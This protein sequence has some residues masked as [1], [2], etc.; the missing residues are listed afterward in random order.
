MTSDLAAEVTDSL[1]EFAGHCCH[2]PWQGLMCPGETPGPIILRQAPQAPRRPLPVPCAST[3]SDQSALLGDFAFLLWDT[4]FAV[5]DFKRR[6]RFLLPKPHLNSLPRPCPGSGFLLGHKMFS[7]YF[8]CNELY[9]VLNLGYQIARMSL[10]KP[11]RLQV[12]LSG[13]TLGERHTETASHHEGCCLSYSQEAAV[14]IKATVIKKSL[15]KNQTHPLASSKRR[16]QRLYLQSAFQILCK[17]IS[18]AESKPQP[19]RQL[20]E[21]VGN[22]VFSLPAPAI[23]GAL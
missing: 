6:Y 4:E 12:K 1:P 2:S 11:E 7:V 20:Q 22:V 8:W 17:C 13:L 14:G 10:G 23:H 21:S 16:K 3:T 18:R 15:Q 19:D 5:F 9:L